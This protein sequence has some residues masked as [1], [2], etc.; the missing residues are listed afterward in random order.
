MIDEGGVASFPVTAYAATNALGRSTG[1]VLEALSAGRTGLSPCRW[2]LPFETHCGEIPGE[3]EPLPAQWSSWDSRLARIAEIALK[4]IASALGRAVSRWG[5][6]RVAVIL[7]TS[8]GG[9]LETEQAFAAFRR[10]G[11]IPA[12]FDFDRQHA[13]HGLVDLVARRTGAQGPGYVVSTACSSSAKVLAAG[14]RLIACGACDAALV[15][16]VDSL[17][18][19]TL[20]G[21]KSLEVL[22]ANPCRPFG[23]ARDGTTIGE[24][25]A[26]LL[27]EREGEGPARLLGVGEGC[28]AHHMSHP[29]PEGLGAEVA[30]VGALSQGGLS[31]CEVDHVNAHG[32]G[33]PLN[34][35][36]E[37]KAIAR[38]FGRRVPVASTK[39]FTGH[40]LGAA[41]ATEA[42]FAVAAIEHG[43][44]PASLF[45]QPIDPAIDLDLVSERRE[46]RCR[47]VLSN[48]F[49]F[50]GS[51]VSALFGAAR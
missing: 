29:H 50:G 27:L 23:A 25:A 13:F 38:L 37:S 6:S 8:T 12:A 39:G 18:R 10:D 3:L 11:A 7:G 46:L 19:T 14:R 31:P 21:F 15:G 41:G 32:T 44:I 1:E 43:W 47:A 2:E 33:T 36:A 35:L 5:A 48:S 45:A 28:D 16:G 34:D 4:E 24:G 26:F 20:C 17:C 22:S 9:I 51:N 40:L 42:V 30:M 49:A